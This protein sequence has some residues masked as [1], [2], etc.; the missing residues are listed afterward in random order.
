MNVGLVVGVFI[1][2]RDKDNPQKYVAAT[3]CACLLGAS[4]SLPD[5]GEELDAPYARLDWINR[6]RFNI[7]WHRH[8]GQWFCLHRGLALSEAI[9][10]L[11]SDGL[12]YPN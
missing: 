10:T 9:E 5:L 6:Y 7:Q 8:T 1:W 2:I 3:T 12:P 4:G 11:R